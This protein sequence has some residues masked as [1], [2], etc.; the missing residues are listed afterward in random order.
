MLELLLFAQLFCIIA[1]EKTR[2]T[3]RALPKHH[4]FNWW[5]QPRAIHSKTVGVRSLTEWPQMHRSGF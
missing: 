4:E 5:H 3:T 2:K 1:L